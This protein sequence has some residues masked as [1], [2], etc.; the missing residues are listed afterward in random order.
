MKTEIT[1]LSG[2]KEFKYYI[3]VK[4]YR[5]LWVYWVIRKRN[6]ESIQK[7]INGIKRGRRIICIVF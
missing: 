5:R 6:I 3:C 1:I 7:S 4:K 2:G